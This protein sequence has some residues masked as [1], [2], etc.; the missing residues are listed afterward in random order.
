MRFVPVMSAEVAPQTDGLEGVASTHVSLQ[1]QKFLHGAGAAHATSRRAPCNKNGKQI[2]LLVKSIATYWRSRSPQW[3]RTYFPTLN[4]SSLSILLVLLRKTNVIWQ[5]AASLIDAATW[6][7]INHIFRKSVATTC[8]YWG[9]DFKSHFPLGKR[10]QGVPFNIMC[11]RTLQAVHSLPN[12]IIR[13]I[14]RKVQAGCT[15]VT[16]RQTDDRRT[17][18]ATVATEKCVAIGGIA[19]SDAAYNNSHNIFYAYVI[20]PSSRHC[21]C[22]RSPGIFWRMT[23]SNE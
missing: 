19:Y 12:G 5:K 11:Q 10:V 16:V 20:N 9:F 2:Q 21:L 8:F 17:D 14:R 1:S 23:V 4:R 3:P 13:F 18:H 6:W 7:T 22:E 15:N